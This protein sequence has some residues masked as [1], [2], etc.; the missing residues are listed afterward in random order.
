MYLKHVPSGDL[1]EILDMRALIDP[2]QASI[3]GRFHSGEELQDPTTF[4]KSELQFPSGED[5]PR[6]WLDPRYQ[7]RA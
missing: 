1:I 4:K 3:A 6:C 5:L 2:F 7:E